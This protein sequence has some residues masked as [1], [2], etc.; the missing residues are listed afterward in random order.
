MGSE[1]LI[2]AEKGFQKIVVAVKSFVD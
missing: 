1:R 2:S